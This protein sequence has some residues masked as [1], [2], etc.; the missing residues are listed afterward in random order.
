MNHVTRIAPSPTG[1]FH[2]GSARTA[3]FN[4][5]IARSTQGKFILRI[6]D[7]D[8][9]RNNEDAVQIIDDAL[10]WLKLDYDLR[11][12][13][14]D[15]LPLYNQMV[16]CL[17]DAGL[18]FYDGNAVRF[19]PKNIPTSW[20]DTIAGDISITSQDHKAIDGL[21]LIR[22]DGM[23]TYHLSSTVD[24]MNLG[25]TWVVRGVD[26]LTNTAKHI[27]L[28]NA[29]NDVL[30]SNIPLPLFS[31][32]GLITQNKK[33]ISKRDGAA[34]LLSYRDNGIDVDAMVNWMLRLGWG[35]TIDDKTTSTILRDRALLLFLNG[36]KM[37]SSPA[38][39][40]PAL[41][42]ALDRK[43]KAMKHVD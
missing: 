4:W 28:W 35:P 38:N 18:A 36:G 22:S 6:D 26:H 5:L 17:L 41:L 25:I 8:N 2:L 43:Y 34:S 12:R 42:L 11:V 27:T 23:P 9:S 1:M 24:D 7:T 13:Q 37:R 15:R 20:N 39:M 40:D 33:K 3:L 14:S 19:K 16:V 32:V 10:A 21:V 31:H 30:S 29:L